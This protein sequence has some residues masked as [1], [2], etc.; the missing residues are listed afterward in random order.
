M[1]RRWLPLLCGCALLAWFAIS[2]WVRFGLMESAAMVAVCA[3]QGASWSCWL[4]AELGSLIYTQAIASLA[5][6]C[7]VPAFLLPGWL[8]RGLAALAIVAA[9]PAMV[10][11]TATFGSI[12]FVLSGLRLLRGPSTRNAAAP[13]PITG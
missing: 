12:A 8:G 1:S 3:E 9:I 6:Y 2:Y 13:G 7:A 11:Y 5:L 4:R 10:L